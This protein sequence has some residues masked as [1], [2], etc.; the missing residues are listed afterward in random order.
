MNCSIDLYEVKETAITLN[1]VGWTD[2]WEKD[3]WKVDGAMNKVL[4]ANKQE[5]ICIILF[6]T[7]LYLRRRYGA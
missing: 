7:G 3:K 6:D 2:D 4:I 5:D 1:I